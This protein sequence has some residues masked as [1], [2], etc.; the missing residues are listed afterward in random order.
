MPIV[1]ARDGSGTP[2]MGRPLTQE[3]KDRLWARIVLNWADSNKDVLRKEMEARKG[4]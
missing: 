3:E 4:E 1:I 2:G